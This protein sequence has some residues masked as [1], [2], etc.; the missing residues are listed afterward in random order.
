MNIE[1][2]AFADGAEMPKAHTC[3][4]TDHS[5]P[6]MFADVPAAAKSL[7]LIVEDPDAPGGTFT[8][9]LLYNLPPRTKFLPDGLA[10]TQ[11]ALKGA[12]QG[13]NDFGALGYGGPCPPPGSPHRYVFTLYALNA[14]LTLKPGATKADLLE[15]MEGR[16][17]EEAKLTGAYQRG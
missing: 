8:H 14:P 13:M 4:G 6:L 1:S 7:A 2:S 16:V 12:A 15:A 3:D 9:W 5:P 11:F 17:L 10:K